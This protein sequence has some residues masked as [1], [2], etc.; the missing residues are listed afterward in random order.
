MQELKHA[1]LPNVL[2]LYF[3]HGYKL[4]NVKRSEPNKK[5]LF[6]YMI[7]FSFRAETAER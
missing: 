5:K 2:S 1:L 7:M 3:I 4:I 6:E